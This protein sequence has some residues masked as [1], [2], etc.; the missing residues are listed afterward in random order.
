VRGLATGS[1]VGAIGAAMLD[2]DKTRGTTFNA[3]APISGTALGALLSG[4]LVQYLPGPT[5]LVYYALLG[6]FALQALGVLLLRETVTTKRGAV[7]SL[8][9]EIAVP[10]R[11]RGPVLTAVPV[12]F[13]V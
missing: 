3:V 5:H 2:V 11:L 13:A 12:L 6:V 4:L 9:P 1:A 10:S 8:R 7:R